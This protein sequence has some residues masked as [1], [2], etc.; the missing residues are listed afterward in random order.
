MDGFITKIDS[1]GNIIW[2][3]Q[4]GTPED[5]MIFDFIIDK[6]GGL[7]A[8]GATVGAFGENK[9]GREDIMVVKLDTAG[10]IEWQKQYGTDNSDIGTAIHV[11]SQGD[12]Y[13]TGITKGLLGKSLFGK[14]DFSF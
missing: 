11:D 6:A 9:F 1:T 10:K 12:I 7:Y 5:D 3:K 13:M 4:I 2:T 14:M 8:T